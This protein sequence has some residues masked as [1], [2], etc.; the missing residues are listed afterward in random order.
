LTRF[1]WIRASRLLDDPESTWP[2]GFYD[3]PPTLDDYCGPKSLQSDRTS[4]ITNN[5]VVGFVARKTAPDK[6]SQ[7]GDVNW[8]FDP[9]RFDNAEMTK[10]ILWVL[11]NHFG[12]TVTE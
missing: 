6:P 9:Y 1:D 4:A 2:L 5:L 12:L 7:V 8:G 11:G 3:E 10:A